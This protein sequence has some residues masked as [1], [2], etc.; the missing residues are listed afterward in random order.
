[1]F[2]SFVIVGHAFSGDF[3]NNDELRKGFWTWT[4]GQIFS[5]A[6]LAYSSTMSYAFYLNLIDQAP[7]APVIA[8]IVT[9]LVAIFAF[10]L[11]NLFGFRTV[12]VWNGGKLKKSDRISLLLVVILMVGVVVWDVKANLTGVSPVSVTTTAPIY[13]KNTESISARYAPDIAK[14]EDKIAQ[15]YARY[16]Y[17]NG[18]VVFEPTPKT[19]NS[20]ARWQSDVQEVEA[21]KA[22]ISRLQSLR[23]RET[24][25]E[26]NTYERDVTRYDSQVI[27]KELMHTGIVKWVYG[28]VLIVSLYCSNYSN[29]ALD[30]M[31]VNPQGDIPGTQ[32]DI[33][34][35]R[36]EG[37]PL[38]E[39]IEELKEML[40]EIRQNAGKANN[41]NGPK[42]PNEELNELL[43]EAREVIDQQSESAHL[44][45]HSLGKSSA[46]V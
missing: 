28:L 39:G 13:E 42:G 33:F 36:D 18:T 11:I 23:D 7:G 22:N 8:G 38:P 43:K 31:E 2:D 35:S 32:E 6:A 12:F 30:Y 34:G 17:P 37:T 10:L 27:D 24:T 14:E 19:S 3:K 5:I 41:P 26:L 40:A 4:A 20:R 15:I 16:T 44:N 1:M 9:A 46:Q 29:L 21:A 25:Q 45:G